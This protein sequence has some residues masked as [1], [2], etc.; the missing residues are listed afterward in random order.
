MNNLIEIYQIQDGQTQVEVRFEQETAWLS[1]VQM[2]A[3]LGKDVRTINEHLGKVFST[4][5]LA[6]CSTIRKFR[7][8]RRKDARLMKRYTSLM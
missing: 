7:I 6:P 4:G 2:A 5:E 3:L 1:Q 8:V